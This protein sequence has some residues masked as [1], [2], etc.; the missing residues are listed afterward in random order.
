MALLFDMKLLFLQYVCTAA[1]PVD[2]LVSH[3]FDMFSICVNIGIKLRN[4][5][6]LCYVALHIYTLRFLPFTDYSS[7]SLFLIYISLSSFFS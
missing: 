4:V 7:P 6:V 2:V 5:K 3:K 1:L